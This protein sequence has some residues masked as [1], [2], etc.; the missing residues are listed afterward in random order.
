[1]ASLSYCGGYTETLSKEKVIYQRFYFGYLQLGLFLGTI[2]L[3]QI[4]LV[5]GDIEKVVTVCK[6]KCVE[7]RQKRLKAK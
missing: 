1:M 6:K 3:N 4:I 7:N 2:L 5:K